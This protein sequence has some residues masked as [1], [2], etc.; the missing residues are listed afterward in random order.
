MRNTALGGGMTAPETAWLVN[1]VP[2]ALTVAVL[3]VIVF[4][5]RDRLMSLL[6]ALQVR[7]ASSARKE[8]PPNLIPD[9]ALYWTPPAIS[10]PHFL[11]AGT[12]ASLLLLIGLSL[13]TPMFVA[14]ILAIPAVALIVWVMMRYFESRYVAE[15]DKALTA[16]V[17]RMSAM[18]R[19]GN[20]Y[21]Q[22]LEKLLADMDDGPLKTEW[23]F[24]LERQGTPLAER[25]GIATAQQVAAA[26]AAQTPSRRHATFLNHLAVAVS[27][28]QDVL[29]T[30]VASA[31]EALQSSDRRR[32]EALTELA[33]MRYS[34]LVVGLAGFG[35]AIYLI[36]TQW[37]RAVAA[38]ST[39]LGMV[40]AVIVC[41][42]LILPIVGGMLLAR[43]D[44][45]DY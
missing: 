20:S 4:V 28:P 1:V 7:R 42:A 44:D 18:L 17:G 35:M 22:M 37:P 12:I 33:Q 14:L 15:I 24:L 19:S 8:L 30:R 43:A 2:L 6:I 26:L 29:V 32:E 3:L 9:S 34:G 38:Y 27:Q 13:V 36:L 10:A 31:Y 21:R 41:S 39:P 16:A 45:V 25:E 5:L 11:A 40:V 23:R